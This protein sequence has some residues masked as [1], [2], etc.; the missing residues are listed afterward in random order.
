MMQGEKPARKLT[1]ISCEFN[2]NHGCGVKHAFS[3]TDIKLMLKEVPQIIR[4]YEVE[5]D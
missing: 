5:L 4:L 1:N 3:Q 2:N